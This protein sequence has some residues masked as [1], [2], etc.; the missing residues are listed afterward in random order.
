MCI[1]VGGGGGGGGVD[2]GVGAKAR[3]GLHAARG[4]NFRINENTV[5]ESIVEHTRRLEIMYM[6]TSLRGPTGTTDFISEKEIWN[7]KFYEPESAQWRALTTKLHML[8]NTVYHTY[9]LFELYMT[10]A[11]AGELL[12]QLLVCSVVIC[13]LGNLSCKELKTEIM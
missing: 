13:G 7:S 5:G 2:W 4:Q 6:P 10:N 1:V 3:A 9:Y 12:Q 8:L 11:G